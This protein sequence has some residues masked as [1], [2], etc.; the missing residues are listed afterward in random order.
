MKL[1]K[2][3][4]LLCTALLTC[5]GFGIAAVACVNGNDPT[6]NSSSSSTP[7]IPDS[8]TPTPTDYVYCIS[9]KNASGFGFGGVNVKLMDGDKELLSG[10]TNSSGNFYV[11]EDDGVAIGNYQVVV[12][13]YPEGY[14][15]ESSETTIALAG[16]TAKTILAPGGLLENEA[17]GGTFYQPGDIMHDFSILADDGTT[18][19]LSQ[20]LAEKDFA[21]INFW[22]TWCGPCKSEFPALNSAY[23]QYSDVMDA[24]A[25]STTDSLSAAAEFRAQEGLSFRVAS[26]QSSA[27]PSMFGVSSIP[28]TVIV[29]R[30]GVVVFNHVGSI[31]SVNEWTYFFDKFTGEDYVPTVISNP[32][33]ENTP[34]GDGT[35]GPNYIEPTVDAPA[36]SAVQSTLGTADGEFSYRWQE[37]GVKQGDEGYDLYNWPWV[38]QQDKDSSGNPV[39]DP[40]LAA[41]NVKIHPSYAILYADYT[42]KAGDVLTFDYRV[43]AE[44]RA[45]YFYVLV[46]GVPVKKISGNHTKAWQTCYAYVFEEHEAG[47]VEIAFSFVKD[48]DGSAYEDV[49]HIKN[50]RITAQSDIPSDAGENA[51]VFRYAATELNTDKNATTQFKRYADVAL[52]PNDNYYHVDLNKN[53]EGEDNEPI[54]FANIWY[55][56][57]WNQTSAWMLSYNGYFVAEGF[58]YNDLFTDYAWESNQ[59]TDLW[60]Y[61]P[62]TSELQ[63]LLQLMT[64]NVTFGRIWNGE[65]HDKEWLELCCYYQH[66]ADEPLEDP[67]KGITF[68]AAIEVKEGLNHVEVPFSI[69]PR[70]FKHKFI[71]TQSGVYRVY[72]IGE[73]DTLAF[74]FSK[75]EQMLGAWSDKLFIVENDYNFEF[76]WEFEAGELYYMLFHTDANI[77]AEYD[78]MIEYI[79]DEYTYLD[80]LA[81]TRSQNTT[82]GDTYISDAKQYA[83][84][85]DDGYYHVLNANGSLGSIIYLDTMRPTIY[86]PNYSIAGAIEG[87]KKLDENGNWIGSYD[88]DGNW[89]G[90][91]DEEPSNR[92]FYAGG[93]D[94]TVRLEEYCY[95]ASLNTGDLKGFIAVDQELFE[96]LIA[97][98][99]SNTEAGEENAWQLT[100]YYYNTLSV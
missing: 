82:T 22:A 49:A 87:D 36:I 40:Y 23:I 13:G 86:Q 53:G 66:Y 80:N 89:V 59:P 57:P 72:S 41:S 43:G 99:G 79:G 77:A 39:G 74:L 97:I 61:T 32:T 31:T 18:F 60:G 30:Y 16:T 44:D 15:V 70:G 83:Y 2:K 84:S 51:H 88:E 90:E 12:D 8:E 68:N 37:E 42:A 17:P 7:D 20:V 4:A 5:L 76:F 75:N 96:I 26:G 92:T 94:Y 46:D 45:D 27:I 73:V 65:S 78:V 91:W 48:S 56:S 100:C 6:N 71:P 93:V 3:A 10:K 50:L 35:T 29:D 98:T 58:N 54:L 81:T 25:I 95:Q 62:V 64:E 9:V 1:F 69:N 63:V 47:E 67:M 34:G 38:I 14:S 52:N 11:E 85:E 55:A 21:L 24:I 28:H 19:S 33:E